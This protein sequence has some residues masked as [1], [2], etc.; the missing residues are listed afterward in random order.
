MVLEKKAKIYLFCGSSNNM[1]LSLGNRGGEG[2][3]FLLDL[4][5]GS[6]I[7]NATENILLVIYVC[8]TH[9]AVMQ[10]KILYLVFLI[11]VVKTSN[12]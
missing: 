1:F 7:F 3:I 10:S 5:R 11:P 4:M 12:F 2:D 8:C 6:S 9:D